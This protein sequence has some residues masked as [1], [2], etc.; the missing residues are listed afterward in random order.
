MKHTVLNGSV[1]TGD[2]LIVAIKK[3]Q[4]VPFPRRH[5]CR[6]TA[7][8]TNK[9]RRNKW[10]RA[11]GRLSP[12]Y[13]CVKRAPSKDIFLRERDPN[14]KNLLPLWRSKRLWEHPHSSTAPS[15]VQSAILHHSSSP[16]TLR[17]AHLTRP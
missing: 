8:T 2:H 4:R 17:S 13:Q 11:H 14:T 9:T 7:A 15:S 5:Y 3:S 10:V 6:L 12:P 1:R 16:S